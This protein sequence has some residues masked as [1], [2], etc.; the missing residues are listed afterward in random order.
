MHSEMAGKSTTSTG[1]WEFLG[2]A[3]VM[4]LTLGGLAYFDVA[5]GWRVPAMLAISTVYLGV[6]IAVATQAICG[7]I[8]LADPLRNHRQ[9]RA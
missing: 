7:Q 3:V 2:G 4:G 6:S 1:V 5:E 8:W 9:Q